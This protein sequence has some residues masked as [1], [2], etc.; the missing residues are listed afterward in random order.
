MTTCHR[1][2]LQRALKTAIAICGDA[3]KKMPILG[4]VVLRSTG[5]GKLEILATDT[6]ASLRAAVPCSLGDELAVMHDAK[7][8][9]EL[10]DA[11]SADEISID[12]ADTFWS[13]IKSGRMKAKIAGLAPAN[14]PT[15]PA[16]T[17]A[18]ITVETAVLQEMINR[19]W[20][21]A[22]DDETK[23]NFAGVH[24][25][26]DGTRTFATAT[27][28]HRMCRLSRAL[29]LPTMAAIVPRSEVLKS[30]LNS[31]PT[32]Q[33]SWTRDHLFVSIEGTSIALRLVDLAY[34]NI[35][36]IFE[37][38]R[39]LHVEMNRLEILASMEKAKVMIAK[40]VPT[41][42]LT[43][44]ARANVA[45]IRV[46]NRDLGEVTDELDATYGGPPL[47]IG[48]NPA[49]VIELLRAM[50]SDRVILELA[51]PLDPALFRQ[52]GADDYC[53]IVMPMRV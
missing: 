13:D 37:M 32:C 35:A 16:P 45:D 50:T 7:K 46:V 29:G 52:V 11:A 44:G 23:P 51:G 28:A 4:N 39:P 12:V 47:T 1:P 2:E 24:L 41:A 15:I 38:P 18:T 19:T 6:V 26:S 25:A 36:P 33:L 31:A 5:M 22:S 43:F 20:F 21:A 53:G 34:P 10:V 27:D 9:H 3:K 49:Y 17:G 42:A 30:F 14:F 8:L 48:F 40:E